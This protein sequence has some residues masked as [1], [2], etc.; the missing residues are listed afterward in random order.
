MIEDSRDQADPD[1]E[2][3]IR[4]ASRAGA[5]C[6]EQGVTL[7]EFMLATKSGGRVRVTAERAKRAVRAAAEA[8]LLDFA[9]DGRRSI[10]YWV[11]EDAA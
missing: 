11:L 6:Q 4:F 7:R 10:R 9:E 2:Q 5:T 3:L 8:G 1:V